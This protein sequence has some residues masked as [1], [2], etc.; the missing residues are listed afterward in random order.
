MAQHVSGTAKGDF[1]LTC[2]LTSK[3]VCHTLVDVDRRHE[4]PER[5][6][7]A[8]ITYGNA[9]SWYVSVLLSPFL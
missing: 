5:E 6:T 7:K 4:A 9:S 1:F 2:E 3:L 8:L